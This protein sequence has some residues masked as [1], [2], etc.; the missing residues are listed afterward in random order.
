MNIAFTDAS[1]AVRALSVVQATDLAV[2]TVSTD[3][4][5]ITEGDT[6]VALRG[7][8]HD[9]HDHVT[10]AASKGAACLVVERP[11]PDLGHLN[12]IVVANTLDALGDLA[13][14]WR[15]RNRHIPL[16]F[17]VGS[18]GKT[19]TKEMAAR[20]VGNRRNLL[21]TKGNLNNLVGLPQT[22]FGLTPGHGAAIVEAGM[23]V[24]GEISRLVD[25]AQPDCVA[26]TNITNAHVGM[27]GSLENLY[28]AKTECL[29]RSSPE[30]VLVLSSDDPLSRRASREYAGRRR[31]IRF[32][33]DPE[34]DVAA[35][36]IEQLTPFGYR[37]DMRVPGADC[38]GIELRAFGRHNV[39]N[40][41]AAAAI[42]SFLDIDPEGVFA[43]IREFVPS[44]DRSQ[45]E[46]IGGFFVIRDYYNA[47]P[48]AVQAALESLADVHAAGRKFAVLGDML[49]LGEF[50]EKYHRQIG[51]LAGR[52]GL[53]C[54]YTVGTRAAIIS[55]AA[56]GLGVRTEHVSD[57]ASIA[58]KLREV[59][60][61][62]DIVLI[63]GSRLMRLERVYEMLKQA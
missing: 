44:G 46:E 32:G 25:I 23:N 26:I 61:P 55:E 16:V 47:S 4:R 50:E 35:A 30:A 3:T 31:V 21:V 40:A 10:E 53:E 24:P 18:T 60:R 58:E 36:N 54:L 1:S 14:Y 28:M 17:L 51:E 2:T 15:S 49:E 43:A 29:R 57:S 7:D 6:F 52:V 11:F 27:L 22:L 13:G 37:F 62:G 56:A 63:K 19:T 9:G 42:A 45:V 8:N 20:M 48:Y 5:T 34:A 33:L 12:Q 41:L 39:T 38:R 59:L